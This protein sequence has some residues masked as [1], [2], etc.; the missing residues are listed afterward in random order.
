MAWSKPVLAERAS[1]STATTQP[2]L[3]KEA[4]T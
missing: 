1:G 4:E 3:T 2:L